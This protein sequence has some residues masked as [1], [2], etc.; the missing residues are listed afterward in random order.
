MKRFREELGD[1][2]SE[3]KKKY[4][5]DFYFDK[6]LKYSGM[7]KVYKYLSFKFSFLKFFFYG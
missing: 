7:E 6:Y 1:K 2:D 5:K 4:L 3:V